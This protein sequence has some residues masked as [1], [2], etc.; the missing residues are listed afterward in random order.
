MTY[1]G[2]FTPKNP[3]KYSG[4]VSNIVYRSLWERQTFRWMDSQEMV[5]KWSSEEVV[6]PYICKT[7]GKPHRYFVDIKMTLKDGRTFLIEIKPK[8]E[9]MP[10][11]IPEKKTRRYITEVMTYA[12]NQSKWEAATE[13]AE[14]RGWKFE[15]WTEDV[16]RGLGLKILGNPHK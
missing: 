5:A 8:K 6:I 4:D 1:R 13:Y 12:K 9:V 7:D 14:D 11:K 3:S 15:V 2:R 10:P 16:L